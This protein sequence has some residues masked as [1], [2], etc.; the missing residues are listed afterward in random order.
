MAAT[1]AGSHLVF[2]TKY[3]REVLDA[4][5]LRGYEN[6]VRKV[7]GDFGAE[8]GS[9]M[10]KTTTCTCWSP[11]PPKVSGPA[12]VNSLKGVP[13]GGRGHGSPAR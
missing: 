10:A 5:M 9:S 2:V 6:A 8:L 11:Y 3:R 1:G 13:P 4:A 12:L 7:C